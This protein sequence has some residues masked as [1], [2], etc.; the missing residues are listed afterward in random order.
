MTL[1]CV[2]HHAKQESKEP[3]GTRVSS[4]QKLNV[5]CFQ[6]VGLS[7][8]ARETMPP[9]SSVS[10][11][12][13]PWRLA[14]LSTGVLLACSIVSLPGPVVAGG[15][16]K[17]AFESNGWPTDDWMRHD[18]HDHV[19]RPGQRSVIEVRRAPCS[20]CS[21]QSIARHPSR[22]L[23]SRCY[24]SRVH[25]RR[26]SMR[27]LPEA[28]WHAADVANLA[29]ELRQVEG[30]RG[31]GGRGYWIPVVSVDLLVV[32]RPRLFRGPRF[33]LRVDLWFPSRQISDRLDGS[34]R[35]L[36]SRSTRVILLVR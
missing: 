4:S 13:P 8:V 23:P 9:R 16:E 35:G 20:D 7:R 31:R 6:S 2:T 36:R 24:R 18:L 26:A 33:G 27:P 1:I 34:R 19:A 3:R 11:P 30:G 5:P 10:R 25:L 12:R 29:A 14:H 28:S 21:I 15:D 17:A 22:L 32:A